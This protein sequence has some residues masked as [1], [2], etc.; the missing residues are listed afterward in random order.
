M[1]DEWPGPLEKTMRE[2]RKKKGGSEWDWA[3]KKE[4]NSARSAKGKEKEEKKR[5]RRRVLGFSIN[6]LPV[7]SEREREEMAK[8]ER[9]GQAGP[10]CGQREQAQNL[11]GPA[12]LLGS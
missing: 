3:W 11:A 6:G 7:W 4:E 9:L 5:R 8:R 10:K 12:A 2:N 1:T